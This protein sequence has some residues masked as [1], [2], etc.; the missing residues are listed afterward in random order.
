MYSGE[1]GAP[2]VIRGAAA[3]H[4]EVTVIPRGALSVLRAVPV[5]GL[6]GRPGKIAGKLRR[7]EITPAEAEQCRYWSANGYIIIPR[8]FAADVLEDVAAM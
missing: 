6:A 4:F 7:G 8:L 1:Y 2:G 5:V 3:R